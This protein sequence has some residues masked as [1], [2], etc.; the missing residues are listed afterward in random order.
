MSAIL[1][2]EVRSQIASSFTELSGVDYTQLERAHNG[3]LIGIPQ[4]GIYKGR[5][6]AISNLLRDLDEHS[7]PSLQVSY[8]DVNNIPGGSVE[9][10]GEYE[11]NSL[12]AGH[13]TKWL[14]KLEADK[15]AHLFDE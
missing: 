6:I 9:V 14:P 8:D 13:D 12:L 1:W 11:I 5:A 4:V 7:N 2:G 15:F 3:M 10:E